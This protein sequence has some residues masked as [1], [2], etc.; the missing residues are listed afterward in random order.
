MTWSRYL[1]IDGASY[2]KAQLREVIESQME[3]QQTNKIGTATE[4]GKDPYD[5]FMEILE[6]VRADE[7]TFN[8]ILATPDPNKPCFHEAG[9]GSLPEMLE[10][11]DPALVLYGL[12]RMAFGSGRFRRTKWV[13]IHWAGP[14]TPMVKR[15]QWNSVSHAMDQLLSTF[16]R[17]HVEM[18]SVTH[19][20]DAEPELV[21]DK[22]KEVI[23][24]DGDDDEDMFSIGAYLEA[25]R[26]HQ[27]EV[28]KELGVVD[29]GPW[30]VDE[31]ISKLRQEDGPI[32]W[33]LCMF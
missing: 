11:L 7:S 27:E 22:I 33:L 25:L 24:S 17:Y 28:C 3:K 30:S 13:F 29:T 6:K 4:L 15:G 20:E 14:D 1:V 18:T 21:I 12:V 5:D 10:Y 8:W 16:G 9:T 32:N 26:E 23:I 2:N 31:T 19:L